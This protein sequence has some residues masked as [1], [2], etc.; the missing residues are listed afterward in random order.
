MEEMILVV[1]VIF[2]LVNFICDLLFVDIIQFKNV[3]DVVDLLFDFIMEEEFKK[4]FCDGSVVDEDEVEDISV[5]ISEGLLVVDVGF[6]F[7]LFMEIDNGR[8][9]VKV[10][11]LG[12]L[13]IEEVF[14]VKVFIQDI[15]IED[16]LGVIVL[17]VVIRLL[18]ENSNNYVVKGRSVYELDCIF[19]WGMVLI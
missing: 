15:K 8:V 4:G 12:E 13:S 16:C 11:I 19:F 18:E 5:V 3:I 9:F 2:S 1:V 10:I 6:E 17:E 7:I 14:I